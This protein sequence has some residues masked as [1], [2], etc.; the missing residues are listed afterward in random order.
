MNNQI[1][2]GD[3]LAIKDSKFVYMSG[4]DA[5]TIWRRHGWVPPSEVRTDYL[6]SKI[7]ENAGSA[8]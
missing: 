5:Q 2:E 4:G 7:R 6:F 1:Q 8:Q 3:L